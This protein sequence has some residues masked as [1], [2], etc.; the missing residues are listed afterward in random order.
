[1]ALEKQIGVLVDVKGKDNL[2]PMID[3]Q[4]KKAEELQRIQAQ[5]R[6]TAGAGVPPHAGTP[7]TP[8]VRVPPP[9]TVP[10][11]SDAVREARAKA[12]AEAAGTPYQSERVRALRDVAKEKAAD[13]T[14][15]ANNAAFDAER[16]LTNERNRAARS[17]ANLVPGLGQLIE[18]IS[19]IK[20]IAADFAERAKEGGGGSVAS[21][22][23]GSRG[24][25]LGGAALGGL[26]ASVSGGAIGRS[27]GGDKGAAVGSILGGAAGGAA[28]GSALLPGV[29]TAIGAAVGAGVGIFSTI[30]NAIE[31]ARTQAER[32]SESM[33]AMASSIVR[34][35]RIIRD[36]R[37]GTGPVTSESLLG[38]P[39]HISAPILSTREGSPERMA[40]IERGIAALEA[41]RPREAPPPILL[42]G[43]GRVFGSRVVDALA[44]AP[45]E[46]ARRRD[47]GL[48]VLRRARRDGVSDVDADGG[49]RPAFGSATS[50]SDSIFEAL[51][52]RS[53][54]ERGIE[55]TES[56]RL[57]VEGLT[58]IV[59]DLGLSIRPG[60]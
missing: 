59:R 47:A 9:S 2:S 18:G 14:I 37:T 55:A 20:E 24:A 15:K 1:M 58:S 23:I 17:A 49:P 43:I 30:S 12:R 5:Q 52:A 22:I 57:A 45:I 36:A 7:E 40:A 25:R 26:A 35:E 19:G 34:S 31:Q 42:D 6:M 53:P 8:A 3:A 11:Q 41:E 27:I 21:R 48:A 4:K 29:G 33:G 10:F 50:V 54:A 56:V 44:I 46:D 51:A 39:G 38:L 28:A 16:K 32:L 60:V 13:N